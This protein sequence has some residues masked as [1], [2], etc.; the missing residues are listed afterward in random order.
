M[1]SGKNKHSPV[2]AKV[3][4]HVLMINPRKTSGKENSF[5]SQAARV[6]THASLSR[7]WEIYFTS[8]GLSFL[9]YEKDDDMVPVTGF[10][11]HL[12]N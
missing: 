6:Q 10:C 12:M 3:L 4:E 9:I 8:L 5:W 2:Y 1:V 11:E 7:L